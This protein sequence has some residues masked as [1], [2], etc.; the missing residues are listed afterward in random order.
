L[1]PF[2]GEISAHLCLKEPKNLFVCCLFGVV[3]QA[4]QMK[5]RPNQHQNNTKDSK[6][7]ANNKQITNK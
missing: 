5:V 4:T 6:Q 1:W 2:W 3:G 7:T